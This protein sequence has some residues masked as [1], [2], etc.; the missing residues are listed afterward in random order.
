MFLQYFEVVTA[1]VE[2][3]KRDPAILIDRSNGGKHER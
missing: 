1:R 3:I 2:R